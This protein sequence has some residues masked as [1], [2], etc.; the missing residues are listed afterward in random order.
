MD[1]SI[2]IVSWNV[3]EK[4]KENLKAIYASS[5][6]FSFEIFVID[7]NSQDGSTKMVKEMFPGVKLIANSSNL[8]FAKGCNQ[9]LE[10]SRGRYKLLLNPDMRVFKNTLDL[11][12]SILDKNPQAAISGCRLVNTEGEVVRQVRAFPAFLD[13]LA[14]V[15]K[16]PHIFPKVLNK[17]LL[18]KF[19]YGK[20]SQVD[21][22]RGAFFVIREE[23]FDLPIKLDE[24]YF[25]WFEEVDFCRQAKKQDKEV[26]YFHEPQCLDYVG[27]S[28]SQ[29]KSRKTQKYFFDS[30]LKY[31]KKWHPSW[32]Y[33]ILKI[34]SWPII[35]LTGFLR[36]VIKIK[37]KFRT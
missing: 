25:L 36:D 3:K 30:M 24:R 19:D 10:K 31:F 14:I 22:I 28:F 37:S 27:Q 7:N 2:I 6:N 20:D 9:G 15:L 8:G 29:L 5:G 33:F 4:L 23:N 18:P 17:Y 21:S 34:I 32:Q 1:L 13:Q 12:L 11:M 16:I 26:W 35:F